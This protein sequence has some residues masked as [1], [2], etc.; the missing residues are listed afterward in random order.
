MI[1]TALLAC[2]AVLACAAA[3]DPLAGIAW[4]D[5]RARTR[6]DYASE[7]V[8]VM[9]FCG[10]CPRA[11]AYMNGTAK[12]IDAAIEQA[13]K[14]VR[15]FCVTP[16]L[17]GSDLEGWA[18]AHGYVGAVVGY[19]PANRES[20]SLN[21]IFQGEIL[22]PA[23]RGQ[24]LEFGAGSLAQVKAAI[25]APG[26]GKPRFAVPELAQAPAAELW[27]ACERE[28]P[29]AVRRLAAANTQLARKKDDP[30]KT[31]V[32]AVYDAVKAACEAEQ[33]AAVAAAPSMAAYE[34]LESL[35]QRYDGL[36]L[37]PAIARLKELGRDKAMKAE[38]AAREVWRQCERLKASQ[39]RSDQ[40]AYKDT[41]AALA[42]RYPDTVYGA[43]AAQ[44]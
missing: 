44:P 27:W 21:N 15:L 6:A 30:L 16:D 17:Q 32:A 28:R 5:G 10:H 40:Q 11:G 38:L 34:A 43:R 3:S 4:T 18:K 42:K 14:P 36:D 37:K 29:Q 22:P 13:R 35:L 39:K 33:T 12:E 23:G 1:R 7:T 31:E 9:Y 24:N 20:I 41:I 19:D 25:A 8:V 2:L 26:V